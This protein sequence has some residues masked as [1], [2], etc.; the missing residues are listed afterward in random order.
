VKSLDDLVSA[1]R[2]GKVPKAMAD[3]LAIEKGWA[4]RRSPVEVSVSQ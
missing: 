1:Y 2:S 3:Q 4:A